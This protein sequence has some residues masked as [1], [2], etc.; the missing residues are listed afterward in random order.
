MSD[1]FV[2]IISALFVLAGAL[3]T[4]C[5]AI[6]LAR[7]RDTLSRMHPAA[8]PQVLGLVLI[9][10]GAGIRVFPNIDLGM[11]VLAGI[12]AVCAAP[13]IAN[14]VG[15]LAYRESVQDGTITHEAPVLEKYT[16]P[17]IDGRGPL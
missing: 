2:E 9:L 5:S 11:L 1:D 10:I 16:G 12:V 13:V 6:G 14:R 17:G 15:N 8:K 3:L 4:L 7:F